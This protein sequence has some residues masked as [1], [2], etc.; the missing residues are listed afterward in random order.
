MKVWDMTKPKNV[1]LVTIDTLRKDVCAGYGNGN[2]RTPFL[3]SILDKC[4]VFQDAQ[5]AGPYTQA[6][7]PGILTS[8]FFL[9]YGKQKT[10]PKEKVMISEVLQKN[11]ITTAAFH[12]NAYLS[13]FF[14]YNRGWD[15]FFDSMQDDVTDMYPFLR[16]NIINQK[17]ETWLKGRNQQKKEKNLFIWVHYMDVHEPYI[18]EADLLNII[19]PDVSM[20]KEE[21]FSLFKDIILPRDVSNPEKTQLL[22]KLYQAKVLEADGYLRELFGILDEHGILSESEII[23]TSDH[24]D[25]FGEHGGLSHDGKMYS[26]LLNVP[27]YLFSKYRSEPIVYTKP[28]SGVDVSP[29]IASLFGLDIP[30]EFKGAPLLPL[31]GYHS[32]GRYAE[33]MD[34]QGH[35]E[36]ETD[37]PIYT[38]NQSNKKII[39][40]S[41]VNE[42]ELFNLAE[43]PWEKRN[44]FGDDEDSEF[45][46]NLLLQKLKEYKA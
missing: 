13:Y 40:K 19:D 31:D 9:E 2:S 43:D 41:G 36:K 18:P 5:A 14:G 37:Q 29:T 34:K 44:I 25:E 38:V 15:M 32:E 7:F 27:M 10:L 45:M 24:G 33:A 26:E 39:Y 4:I 6:S 42:W 28:V 1:V 16:G 3:H 35:K 21:M 17:V 30:D 23:L 46:K 11:G 20:G 12:S 8:S 22:K